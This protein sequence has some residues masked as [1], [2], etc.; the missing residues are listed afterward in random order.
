MRGTNTWKAAEKT[1]SSLPGM[2]KRLDDAYVNGGN[3]LSMLGVDVAKGIAGEVGV[4]TDKDVVRYVKNP[5]LIPGLLDTLMR[6]KSGKIS[7]DSYDN[8]KRLMDISE[9]DAIDKMDKA[10][11]R[12][13]LLFSRREKI[14]LSEARYLLDEEYNNYI[15][16]E[17]VP[18]QSAQIEIPGEGPT[19]KTV[20]KKMYSVSTDKTKIIFSDNTEE[21]VDGRQ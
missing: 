17:P 9:K 18:E 20:V 5:A 19:E 15:P 4:L 11:M 6:L 14:S 2:R 10:V 12:E 13:A 3:T 16:E 1:N 8:L 21:I 7:K